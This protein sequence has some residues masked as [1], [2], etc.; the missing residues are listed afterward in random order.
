MNNFLSTPLALREVDG[1]PSCANCRWG[2]VDVRDISSRLRGCIQY[3][4]STRWGWVC[5]GYGK[6]SYRFF[7]SSRPNYRLTSPVL[8]DGL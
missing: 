8:D 1:P 3:A 4:R 7:R 5:D 2:G 6:E